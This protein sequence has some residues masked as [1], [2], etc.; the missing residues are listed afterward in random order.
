MKCL[1]W[2]PCYLSGPSHIVSG[3]VLFR[4]FPSLCL[5]YF[6]LQLSCT[7]YEAHTSNTMDSVNN[8]NPQP[9]FQQQQ[10]QQQQQQKQQ[11]SLSLETSTLCGGNVPHGLQKQQ[12]QQQQGAV[13]SVATTMNAGPL[14]PNSAQVIPP[15]LLGILA[16]NQASTG[17]A[18]APTT[19]GASPLFPTPGTMAGSAAYMLPDGYAAVNMNGGLV[20]P[21]ALF[22]TNMQ[23]SS[24]S[25]NDINM[26]SQQ[27]NMQ[28]QQQLL[29]QSGGS[30]MTLMAN[31]AANHSNMVL[32][33]QA[34]GSSSQTSSSKGGGT[35]RDLNAVDRAKQ[36][37]DRN[38][39][40]ARTTRIRK[41]AYVQKLRELVEGLH[42]EVGTRCIA[43]TMTIWFFSSVSL[44]FLYS[45]ARK[46]CVA[47]VWPFSTS[48]TCRMFDVVWC[49]RF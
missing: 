40:H 32:P 2:K 39:E 21:N 8:S 7:K 6:T 24:N 11:P 20:L 34:P 28:F 47:G 30:H 10:Q 14:L 43:S 25:S 48:P 23:G 35:R 12:Q 16:N 5:R 9:L 4:K 15:H 22:T 27:Q 38:R 19:S 3:L 31:M 17:S 42:A 41:K 46:K 33:P 37:R 49:V 44:I 18:S 26:S 1:K 29:M 13:R 45:S 36:N